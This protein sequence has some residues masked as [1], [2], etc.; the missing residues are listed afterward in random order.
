MTACKDWDRFADI[1]KVLV[2]GHDPRLHNSPTIAEYC[3]FANYFFDKIQDGQY[4]RKHALAK[5]VFDFVDDISIGRYSPTQV[6]ITNLCNSA[7][8]AAPNGKT[9][10][11]PRS[12][13][14]T[15]VRHI[16]EILSKTNIEVIFSMSAQ[17]NYWLQELGFYDSGNGFRED[18][19]P[20]ENGTATHPHYYASTIEG[21]F[22]K[23]C[24]NE[25]KADNKYSLF[26]IL[27]VKSYPLKDKFLIYSQNY[28]RMK[29]T[30]EMNQHM[31]TMGY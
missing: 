11:I 12:K 29:S 1:A 30:L 31:R 14:T 15:G 6:Y 27:H 7:L 13:A 16:R 22:R 28:Q 20:K 9:V 3:F 18:A 4:S 24:G 5:S 19:R 21:S 26:P 2:I 17:V 8:P 25:Y 23:I 10:Y